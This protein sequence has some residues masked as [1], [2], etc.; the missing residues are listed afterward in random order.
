MIKFKQFSSGTDGDGLYNFEFIGFKS[1]LL[2]CRLIRYIIT[3]IRAPDG[4]RTPDT[5][6]IA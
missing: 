6:V 1:I 2:D 3:D 5:N 4:I